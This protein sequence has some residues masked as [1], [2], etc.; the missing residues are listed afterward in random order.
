MFEYNHFE[1]FV[2]K[3][4]DVILTDSVQKNCPLEDWEQ[5]DNKYPYILAFGDSKL[6]LTH[7][8]IEVEREFIHVMPNIRNIKSKIIIDLYF[9]IGSVRF[10]NWSNI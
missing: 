9:F 1:L 6:K 2:V 5:K 10:Y 4:V 3:N 8:Y 7:F